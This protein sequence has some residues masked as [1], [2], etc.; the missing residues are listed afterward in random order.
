MPAPSFTIVPS[1]LIERSLCGWSF[2]GL[3]LVAGAAFAT[4]ASP[5]F[6]YDHEVI[7]MPALWLAAGLCVA[8]LVFATGVP[9]LLRRTS[10]VSHDG[11]GTIQ[12][13]ALLIVIAAGLAARLILIPSEPML[14]DDFQRYLWEGGVVAAGLN[15]YAVSPKQARELPPETLLNLMAAASGDIIERVAHAGLR[16][17]YPPVAQAAFALAHKLK[18]WDL[19]AW[20]CVVLVLDATVLALILALLAETGRPPL[21]AALYWWNPLV[22]KE[23]FNSGHMEPVLMA[24]LLLALLL[25]I[26]QRP[27]ASVAALGVAVGAKIWPVL[28]LP[29]LLRPLLKD[30]HRLALAIGLFG[31]M[32]ALWAWPI[33]QGGL[34][35]KSGFVAYAANWRTNSAHFPTLERI[36]GAVGAIFGA[37]ASWAGS[38]ARMLLALGGVGIAL[39]QARTPATDPADLVRRVALIA[40]ALVLLSPAQYPW[41]AIW[42]LPFLPFLP[43]RCFMVL[44]VTLPVYYVFFHFNARGAPDIFRTWVVWIIWIPAWMALAMD[45]I[46]S[47]RDSMLFAPGQRHEHPACDSSNEARRMRH[48]A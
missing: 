34:D 33:L 13:T 14:E 15:P 44:T 37:P 5:R 32:M 22:L 23:L 28:L 4:W 19:V 47:W 20:K 41:Y 27:F 16:T 11:T 6:G 40:A 29:L 1:F 38:G 21:W 12:R 43:L 39:W 36:L 7:D 2:G 46:Q 48:L 42:F 24:P 30:R 9:A 17:I 8:G 31:A 3:L 26:R 45:G 25:A 35:D 18:P 10:S